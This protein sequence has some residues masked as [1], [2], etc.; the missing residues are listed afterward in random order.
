M[1]EKGFNAYF[2]VLNRVQRGA[3]VCNLIAPHTPTER[4]TEYKEQLKDIEL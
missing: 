4:E 2:R 3:G 1:Q